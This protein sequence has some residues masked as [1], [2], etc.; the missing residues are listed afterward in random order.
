MSIT[1]RSRSRKSLLRFPDISETTL[2]A[3]IAVGFLLLHILTAIVLMPDAATESAA[4]R[5]EPKAALTD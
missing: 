4:P 3:V 1:E 5:A 2:L